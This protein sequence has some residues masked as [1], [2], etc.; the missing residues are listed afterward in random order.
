ME[1]NIEQHSLAELFGISNSTNKVLIL[2]NDNHNDFNFVIE[3]LIK[4][5]NH[6]NEQASQCAL[7]AH[8]KG[9]CDIKK[10]DFKELS[11]MKE[12]LIERGLNAVIQ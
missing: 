8:T 9:K 6:T 12:A 1:K 5:C 3:S 11:P 7:A 2:F 10:G 4:V